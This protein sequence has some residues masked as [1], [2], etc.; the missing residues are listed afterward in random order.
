LGSSTNIASIFSRMLF[1]LSLLF[2]SFVKLYR[3]TLWIA[4]ARHRFAFG[5]FFFAGTRQKVK[6]QMQSGVK[7]PQ[8]R[9]PRRKIGIARK[10]SRDCHVRWTRRIGVIVPQRAQCAR[11][12]RNRTPLDQA[13]SRGCRNHMRLPAS[14]RTSIQNT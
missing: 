14:M 8:S 7:P 10:V 3:A 6:T 5:F 2:V 1:T 9:V 11:K 13:K 4:V 12:M